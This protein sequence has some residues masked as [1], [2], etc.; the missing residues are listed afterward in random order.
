MKT[1]VNY[2]VSED[3]GGGLYL[4]VYMRDTPIYCHTGY[5]YNR[6][7]L[8]ADL[9]ILDD[10]GDP[11]TGSWEGGEDNPH[12]WDKILAG[13][14]YKIIAT[15]ANGKRI[16]YPDRMGTAGRLEFYQT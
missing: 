9:A 7:Q 16:L 14:G 6:G 15:G 11:L 8:I 4:M 13:D 5:E 2:A 1:K 12:D 10:G 3:G